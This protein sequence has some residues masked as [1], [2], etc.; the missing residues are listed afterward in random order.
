M[1]RLMTALYRGLVTRAGEGA[2]SDDPRTARTF[3]RLLTS[4]FLTKL[5]DA[6]TNPKTVLAWLA[7]SLGV[8][9]YL[10]GMLVPVREAGALLP[11]FYIA[12]LVRRRALRKR[13]WVL[14]A[15]AQGVAVLAI[16]GAAALLQ[17]RIAGL[18][19]LALT[20]LFALARALASVAAKDVLGKT[21]PKGQRGQITGWSASL[22]GLL[23][24]AVGASIATVADYDGGAARLVTL[25][26]GAALLW[27]AA[28]AIYAGIEEP[29]NDIDTEGDGAPGPWS[30]F[31]LLR[32]DAAFRDFVVVRALLLGS[33]LTAPYLVMLAQQRMGGSVGVL[34]S[35]VVAGGLASLI[36]APIWGRLADRSSRAVMR[37]AALATAM[38]GAAVAA[39]DT[40]LPALTATRW[41]LPA[42]FFLLSIA[43]AGA[44]VGRKTYVVDL[45]SGNRRTDYVAIG[46]SVIGVCLL[47]TGLIGLAE[48]LLTL[49]G[50][51]LVLSFMGLASALY[52]RR[53]PRVGRG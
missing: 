13:L 17:G 44:R 50:V 30:R 53:L 38:L 37:S 36:S 29:R 3:F 33:A 24:V 5:G 6:V 45:A 18:V 52:G 9:V 26:A 25:L 20:G 47:L 21:I 43:H 40:W 8:P 7:T 12:G 23:T 51:I 39:A 41:F 48:P 46:N 42:A 35:F 16:A 28:A 19:I 22:A 10:V 2:G 27:F 49:P 4:Y 32:D 14:G 15:C 1:H 31:R 34:G 11:Q